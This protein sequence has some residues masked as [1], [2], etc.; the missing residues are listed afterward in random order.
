MMMLT[1]T[2]YLVGSHKNVVY[3]GGCEFL[4]KIFGFFPTLLKNF[5]VNDDFS[6][7]E[8]FTLAL[9]TVAILLYSQYVV[10]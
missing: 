9:L 6:L 7:L 3:G 8:L 4:S 2:W 1:N 10:N 5:D